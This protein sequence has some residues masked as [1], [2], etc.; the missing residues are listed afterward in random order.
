MARRPTEKCGIP[1]AA[2]RGCWERGSRPLRCTSNRQRSLQPGILV[3]DDRL[4]GGKENH[5]DRLSR[6]HFR[7]R[8]WVATI[9]LN[10]PEKLNAISA[11][12]RNDLEAALREVRPS[13]TV[14]VVRIRGAGRAFCAGYDLSNEQGSQYADPNASRASAISLPNQRTGDAGWQQG[15]SEHAIDREGLREGIHCWLW[16]YGYRKPIIAQ[17]HG[18]CLAGGNEMIGMCDIVFAAS[19]ARFGHPAVRVSGIPPSL[20]VWPF[21]IGMLKTKE[22][23]FTG[24]MIGGDEAQ[25]IGMVNRVYPD[26]QLDAET[27]AF[28][29]RVALLPLDQLT[30]AK[31]AIN[32]WFEIAGI[33]TAIWEGAEFDAI[34]H[35]SPSSHEFFRISREQGLKSALAWRDTP[36]DNDGGVKLPRAAAR[37]GGD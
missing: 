20:G 21:R 3:H 23:L 34:C 15:E 1:T 26:D 18:Y 22:L 13:N 35:E 8:R 37:A 7:C 4:I 36:F 10:R 19:G 14:R 16:V 5:H 33:R 2:K 30:G 6:H 31:H 17:M 28:C 9:T 12:L 24:D 25:R 32:R 29:K 11:G 27:L